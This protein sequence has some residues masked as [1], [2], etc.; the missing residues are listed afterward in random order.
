ML[1][2]A[3]GNDDLCTVQHARCILIV[4]SSCIQED[5]M[6]FLS[7]GNS[8]LIHDSTVATVEVIFRILSDQGEI[9]HGQV[10]DI[11]KVR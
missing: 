1:H 9:R 2:L 7:H 5:R 11:K 10:F 8:K 6:I 3:V 4:Q